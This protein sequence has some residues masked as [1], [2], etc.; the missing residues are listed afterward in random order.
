MKTDDLHGRLKG[1]IKG[2][3]HRLKALKASL[4]RQSALTSD[5]AR[6]D[7]ALAHPDYQALLKE[8][9]GMCIDFHT[10]DARRQTWALTIEVWRSQ[11]ANKRQGNI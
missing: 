3:E 2:Y 7:E 11:N 1:S 5:C 8:Y 9:E 4:K 6:E 10:I